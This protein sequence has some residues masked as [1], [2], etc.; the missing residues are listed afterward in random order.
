MYLDVF[1]FISLNFYWNL[2]NFIYS[3]HE[4]VQHGKNGLVFKNKAELAS[5]IQ[6]LL[7]EFPNVPKLEEFRKN[8]KEFQELRWEESWLKTVKPILYT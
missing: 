6:D 7:N 5:Q 2:F 4:L 8:L 3:L 1:M